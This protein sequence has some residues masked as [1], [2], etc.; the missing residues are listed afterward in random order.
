MVYDVDTP[1][2]SQLYQLHDTTSKRPPNGS[3]AALLAV[4]VRSGP[5]TRTLAKRLS[6]ASAATHAVRTPCS[7]EDKCGVRGVDAERPLVRERAPTP[8]RTFYLRQRTDIARKYEE[9]GARAVGSQ[10]LAEA[11]GEVPMSSSPG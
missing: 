9:M 10:R 11:R 5:T 3:R 1:Q 7:I 4:L 2:A 8:A 6:C